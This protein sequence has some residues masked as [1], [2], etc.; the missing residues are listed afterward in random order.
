MDS[1]VTWIPNQLIPL[2]VLLI[3]K[4]TALSEKCISEDDN[5]GLLDKAG[6]ASEPK[7]KAKA[8]A[9]PKAVAKAKPVAKAVAKAK[10]VAKAVEK[11]AAPVAVT[12]PKAN[13]EKKAKKAR[14]PRANRSS[15][16]PDGFE[17]ANKLDR[18]MSWFVNFAWN[19]GVLFA[20]L[21][22]M[23]SDTGLVT[24][25]LIVAALIMMVLNVIL[26]PFKT[27]RNLGQFVSRIKYVNSEGEKSTPIQGALSN[28]VGIL[29]LFGFLFIFVS[30]S[31]IGDKDAGV[32]PIIF[33]VVGAIFVILYIV[34]WQFSK[35]SDY[36]QGLYDVMFGVY[37]VKHVPT[38]EEKAS[39]FWAKFESMGDYGDKFAASR[40]AK[41]EAQENE[42]AKNSEDGSKAANSS[43][44]DK[45][46]AK[47][48]AKAKPKAK[49]S[50]K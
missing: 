37:M 35:A 41:K 3:L 50:K 25:I 28:S 39:G 16:I 2:S 4:F 21:F 23:A 43:D 33:T 8:V 7:P 6:G 46:K 10:P 13:K 1:L 30:T 36:N 14:K 20:A 32:G 29:A 17:M 22:M 27:G 19:F 48:K 11:V 12:E 9:K 5:M 24:T 34:N 44:P 38:A 15:G 31:D 40:E 42:A 18:T 49:A 45:P 47:A 26:L